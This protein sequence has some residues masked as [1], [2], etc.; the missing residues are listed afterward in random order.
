MI[1]SQKIKKKVLNVSTFTRMSI[2]ECIA[3]L[4]IIY[5]NLLSLLG[6][7]FSPLSKVIRITLV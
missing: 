3:T 6:L 5:N 1:Y 7:Q 4:I 2:C